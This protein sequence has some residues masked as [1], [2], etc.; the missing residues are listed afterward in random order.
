MV[1]NGT[2]L[3]VEDDDTI[4][5]GMAEL[6]RDEGYDVAEAPH[7]QAALDWLMQNPKPCVILL[8]LYMPVMS[9]MDFRARQLTH[10]GLAS[11][12]VVVV[13]AVSRDLVAG[14]KIADYIGKPINVDR[15]LASVDELC[16][17]CTA[18]A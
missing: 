18:T 3:I 12:P 2:V 1:K 7:G 4:R 15:L 13:S 9:G 11:I 10:P 8:D 16:G 6:L 5:E 14:L 17:G